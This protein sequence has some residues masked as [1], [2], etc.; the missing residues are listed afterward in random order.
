MRTRAL[1]L[2]VAAT[3]VVAS[4]GGSPPKPALSRS[5][6]A[7]ATS[8][9]TSP[10]GSSPSS[11]PSI[12]PVDLPAGTPASYR[13]DVDAA[14]LPAEALVPRG[15]TPSDIWPAI[16]PDGTQFAL[17]AFAAPSDDPLRRARGIIEWRRFDD[18]PSWRPVYGV[19]DPANVGV[20]DIHTLVGDATADGSPDAL[21]FEDVG[22]SGTCGTWRVIDL[23]SNAQVYRTQTCDSTYDIS[24]DP[25][26][27]VLRAAVYRPGDAHCCPSATRTTMFVY[28]GDGHWSVASRLVTPNG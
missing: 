15:T 23:A 5:P 28:D 16:A 9:V 12:P 4:C 22:G 10:A 27:L 2:L 18:P 1:A 13:Q 11:S 20:L 19:F 3:S 8:V 17:V 26:G 7:S 24:T 14:G 25:A 6:S 21:T